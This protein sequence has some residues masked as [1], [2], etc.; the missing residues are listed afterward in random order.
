MEQN[1][2][3]STAIPQTRGRTTRALKIEKKYVEMEG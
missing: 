1:L 2:K 3:V